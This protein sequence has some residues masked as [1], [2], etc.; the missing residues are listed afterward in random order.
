MSVGERLRYARQQSGLTGAQVKERTAIGESSLS[1]FENGKREPSLSQLHALATAYRRSILFF[2]SDAPIDAEVVLWRQRPPAGAEDVESRFLRLCEQYHN[3]EVWCGERTL[4]RLPSLSADVAT[5]HYRDATRLAKQVRD[6]MQ[7]GDRPGQT[8]LRVLEEVCGVK[9]F[10]LTFEPGGTAASV[11]SPTFGP[12]VLL[13]ATSARWR[14]NHDLAHELFHLL[15]WPIFRGPA[16]DSNTHSW[17][18]EEKLATCFASN[19][20]M[21]DEAV[22]TAIDASIE[23]GKTR[24]PALFSVARQF[25]VSVESLLWRMLF[26]YKRDE[27]TTKR[28]IERAKQLAPVYEER[29]PEEPPMLPARYRALAVR[30]LRQGDIS[31]GRFAEYLGITR[32]EAMTF[33]EQEAVENDDVEVAPA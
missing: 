10:H 13:N 14:R 32:Q 24:L 26:L 2:L 9:V 4:A 6:Q 7:L 20:L 33:V 18:W 12:A 27:A 17:E 16:N 15:T 11:L 30:A 1:D 28:D 3:L 8:L 19:L 23:D 31:L 5:F 25:D 21:P 29:E 22:R